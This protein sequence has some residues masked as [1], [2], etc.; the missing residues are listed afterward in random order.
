MLPSLVLEPPKGEHWI[1]EIKHDGYR[2]L[3]VID[4]GEAR[5]F[6]RSGLDWSPDYR[7]IVEA[8]G[9]LR[10]RSAVIDG[11]VVVLD[12]EGRSDFHAVKGA[13]ARGGRGLLFIAFDLLFLDGR[14]LRA[15]PIEERRAKLRRL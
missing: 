3:L 8:A 6:T 1:H 10:C 14:D 9:K 5:A 11:E 13:I 15:V 7:P 12:G 2:T 4:N